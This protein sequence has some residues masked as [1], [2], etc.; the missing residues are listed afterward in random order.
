MNS[1]DT[2]PD[3]LKLII[4]KDYLSPQDLNA[5]ARTNRR[6]YTLT[7]R[8]RGLIWKA[9]LLR[10]FDVDEIQIDNWNVEER[11]REYLRQDND[12]TALLQ[13]FTPWTKTGDGEA[14]MRLQKI[15]K[16]ARFVP[17]LIQLATR[18]PTATLP[19]LLTHFPRLNARTMSLIFLHNLR[20][21]FGFGFPDLV[22][23]EIVENRASTDLV[24]TVP[25][26]KLNA[27]RQA[28]EIS[29]M[30][31][32]QSFDFTSRLHAYRNR[33]ERDPLHPRNQ[34]GERDTTYPPGYLSD[35]IDFY[36]HP[37]H[38]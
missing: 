2:L 8:Y 36:L 27:L 32:Q 31:D 15:L 21:D 33:H 20:E 10:D 3:D 35:V 18:Q 13:M 26:F 12:Q 16:E 23:L 38:R 30:S 28:D 7:Q 19:Q 17:R 14:D 1:I 22:L 9:F 34:L 4:F 11:K 37:H 6:F 5:L 25:F 24:T 29:S